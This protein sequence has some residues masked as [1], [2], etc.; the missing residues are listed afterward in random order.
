[1]NRLEEIVES[2]VEQEGFRL[3]EFSKNERKKYI[4]VVIYKKE[5]ITI[6]DC[7]RVSKDLNNDMEFQAIVKGEY[8]IEVSSPG[9]ERDL[10]SLKE[11]KIF[12]GKEVK[13]VM[14]KEI[15]NNKWISG[16]LR[17]VNEGNEV[18]V[19]N[20]YNLYTIP[21]INIKRGKLISDI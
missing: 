13:I 2:I 9:V 18:L 11:Y 5:G 19:E 7:E 6:D 14:D 21:Y 4:R 20:G 17:G 16:I 8:D 1:M 12:V 10:K 15:D 3:V